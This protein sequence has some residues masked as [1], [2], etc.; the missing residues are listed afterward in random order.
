MASLLDIREII[1]RPLEG[2]E[3]GGADTRAIVHVGAAPNLKQWRERPFELELITPD[4]CRKLYGR[5][6]RLW[7]RSWVEAHTE[8]RARFDERASARYYSGA[9]SASTFLQAISYEP[10]IL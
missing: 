4:G 5:T 8:L 6:A 10:A 2:R 9:F 1:I 7:L 3:S